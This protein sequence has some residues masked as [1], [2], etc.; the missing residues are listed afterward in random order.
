MNPLSPNIDGHR[1]II[2]NF[3][4]FTCSEVIKIAAI[5]PQK[6]KLNR[7][8]FQGAMKPFFKST[9]WILHNSGHLPYFSYKFNYYWTLIYRLIRKIF[10]K[11]SGQSR[12]GTW[13]DWTN[14]LNSSEGEIL[15]NEYVPALKKQFPELFK[16]IDK[17]VFD[18][19]LS[20]TQRRNL[21]QLGY[22]F[23]KNQNV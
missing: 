2:R 5:A 16:N 11:L 4:P 12:G 6:I 21:L 7:I 22:H 23:S 1:R 9:K 20:D 14:F 3:E 17:D 13:F 18:S 10:R 15:Y 19:E 8:L